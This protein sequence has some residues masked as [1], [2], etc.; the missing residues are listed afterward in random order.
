MLLCY[1]ISTSFILVLHLFAIAQ[2]LL[3]SIIAR[4]MTKQYH[5]LWLPSSFDYSYPLAFY[6]VFKIT[7]HHCNANKDCFK[8]PNGFPISFSNL[9]LSSQFLLNTTETISLAHPFLL[10]KNV[11]LFTYA[12]ARGRLKDTVQ[13]CIGDWLTLI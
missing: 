7:A 1:L 9:G 4:T 13:E 10:K 5:W 3:S 8:Y 2:L 6:I 11:F 12:Q